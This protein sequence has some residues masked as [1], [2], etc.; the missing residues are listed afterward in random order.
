[1]DGAKPG[2]MGWA[3]GVALVLAARATGAQRERALL[4]RHALAHFDRSYPAGRASARMVAALAGLGVALGGRLGDDAAALRELVR[5]ALRDG[6]ALALREGR[7]EARAGAA[8]MADEPTSPVAPRAVEEPESI[9]DPRWSR[10]RVPVGTTLSAV[11]TYAEIKSP[12]AATVVVSEVDRGSGREEVARIRTRIPA[13]SGDHAIEW[14]RSPDDAAADLDA[15]AATG[16]GGPLEYRFRVESE[17]L[18]CAGESGPL[19]LTN[20]V[21]VD[22]VKEEDRSAH[23][24]PRIVV[25]TDAIGEERRTPSERGRARFEGVLVG[26]V[27][28]RVAAPSFTR[29]AWGAPRVPV[30]EA[31]E[32]RFSYADAI[33]GMKALVVVYEVNRD[34]ASDEVY[35]E[36]VTLN[37]AS[38]E[39]R[40]PFTRSEEEAEG[41]I[42]EDA[43]SGDAGPIEY[44]FAVAA[45]GRETAHSAALWLTHTV[46]VRVEEASEEGGYPAGA[47]V[48]LVAADGTEHRA[49]FNGEEASFEGVVC[50][51]MVVRLDLSRAEA[52]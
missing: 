19:W 40:M 6:R 4:T 1:M 46:S 27:R 23:E 17:R 32:A 47:E 31:V 29:L 9:S 51:P 35:R 16:D 42:A 22:I 44:R 38:G 30:G 7:G 37:G 50:G 5:E 48:V 12:L 2:G 41:D 8:P 14:R 43:D 11:V 26:P 24:A 10:A 3:G 36:E 20:T 25:L 52:P 15:D 21:A 33:G 45:E 13:G 28:L 18:R 34:G 49:P 39:V